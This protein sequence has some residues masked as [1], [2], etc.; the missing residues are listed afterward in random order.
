MRTKE[1][2]LNLKAMKN[3]EE[4][5]LFY[6][7][8]KNEEERQKFMES[9]RSSPKASEE[10]VKLVVRM[11]KDG[12]DKIP[13]GSEGLLRRINNV[14]DIKEFLGFYFDK[15]GNAY[16]IK[17]RK[18]KYTFISNKETIMIDKQ[19]FRVNTIIAQLFVPN[20]QNYDYVEHINGD[21]H[22]LRMDNLKWVLIPM[23]RSTSGLDHYNTTMTKEK[24][25]LVK[26]LLAE[27]KL[28]QWEIAKQ[29]GC[30][31]SRVTYIKQGVS[32][33]DIK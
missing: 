14:G 22:D 26:K 28:R 10:Y 17:G 20:P 33:S 3:K 29:V 30:S 21:P 31:S 4:S 25:L 11:F 13:K 8:K 7:M 18:L 9:M 5:S 15:M 2:D 32:Y 12:A 27:G 16:N 1:V 6:V 23:R 19:R 24:V